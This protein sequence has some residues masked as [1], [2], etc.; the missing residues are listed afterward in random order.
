MRHKVLKAFMAIML[1]YG[2]SDLTGATVA[3]EAFR[4]LSPEQQRPA[5]AFILPDYQGV[6]IDLADL[7]SK[8]VV[9]RFW[10]TW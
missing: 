9:V 3:L 10:A 4:A 6:P 2:L 7:R 1:V 5:P 8:V